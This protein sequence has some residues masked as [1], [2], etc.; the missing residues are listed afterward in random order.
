MEEYS[1]IESVE[2][3]DTLCLD[4]VES[5]VYVDDMVC[6][7]ATLTNDLKKINLK[8]GEVIY[9][10]DANGIKKSTDAINSSGINVS[11]TIAWIDN[12]GVNNK[13]VYVSGSASGAR[14]PASYAVYVDSWCVKNVTFGA[15]SFYDMDFS[16]KDGYSFKLDINVTSGSGKKVVLKVK[17]RMSD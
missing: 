9:V 12:T 7:D 16:N 11:G 10:L 8:N 4:E 6:E 2:D 13:L 15:T 5:E 3:I 17:T 1:I 14:T